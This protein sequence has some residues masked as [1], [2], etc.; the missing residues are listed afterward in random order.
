MRR[1]SAVIVDDEQLAREELAYLL[2]AHPEIEIVGDAGSVGEAA[3][4]VE[5]VRPDLVFLDIELGSETGFDL[6]EQV[7][8]DAHVVFVTAHDEFALRAFEVNALDYLMKPVDA[9]RLSQAVER[10]LRRTGAPISAPKRLAYE[11]VVLVQLDGSPR[12]VRLSS[13]VCIHAERDYSRL[14]GTS[15]PIGLTLKRLGDWERLLPERQFCRIQRSIIVN[16]ER[17]SR[18]EPWWNGSIQIHVDTLKDPLTMSRRYA[19]QFRDR[20]AV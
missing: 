12:L 10:F 1:R 20:F 11:D 2:Q 5:R 15:G 9:S 13:I 17:V 14:I 16:C 19:R 4:L 7:R 6:F 8:L 18:L 3:L